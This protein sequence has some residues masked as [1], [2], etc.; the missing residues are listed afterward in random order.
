MVGKDKLVA[1]K[2]IGWTARKV[3][4]SERCRTDLMIDCAEIRVSNQG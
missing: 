1:D 4:Q 2:L 3:E